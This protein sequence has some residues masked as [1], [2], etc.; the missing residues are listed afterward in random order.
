[1]Q[2]LNGEAVDITA[3]YLLKTERIVKIRVMK[4][5]VAIKKLYI[6]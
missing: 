5:I 2:S 1:M 4:V 3:I 6:N